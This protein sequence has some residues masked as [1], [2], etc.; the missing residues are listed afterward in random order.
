MVR[1]CVRKKKGAFAG[2]TV[3]GEIDSADDQHIAV[4]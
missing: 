3:G 1:D 2:R 4:A